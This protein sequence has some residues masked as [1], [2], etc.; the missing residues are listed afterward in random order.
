MIG[1]PH[2]RA[3]LVLAIALGIAALS[4]AAG[5]ET[6]RMGARAPDI[7]GGPWIGS[8]PLTLAALRGR[9]VL[10]EFWTYG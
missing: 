2:R 4:I 5:A 3:A 7:T 9:V 10:V 8:A 1:A 6:L